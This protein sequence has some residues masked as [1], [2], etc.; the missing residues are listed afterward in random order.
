MLGG[1]RFD[2]VIE[3]AGAH[4]LDGRFD[5]AKAGHHHDHRFLRTR[6]QLAQQVGALAVGQPHV[7]DHEV[8]I[9]LRQIFAGRSQGG[10]GGHF[11][12]AVAQEL[13]KISADDRIV[14]EDDNF[15]DSHHKS[16]LPLQYFVASSI[17]DFAAES[18]LPGVAVP[19]AE[20]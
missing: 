9:V 7:G 5:G 12:A 17:A 11:E 14:F 13:F 19:S 2:E 1:E 4:A 10:G 8:K 20:V 6:L 3:G 15:F 16:F 18:F